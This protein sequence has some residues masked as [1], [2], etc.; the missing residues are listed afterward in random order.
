ME[1]SIKKISRSTHPDLDNEKHGIEYLM[2]KITDIINYIALNYTTAE[3]TINNLLSG[4]LKT[5]GLKQYKTVVNNII[6]SIDNYDSLSI[7]SLNR[8]RKSLNFPFHISFL[9]IYNKLNNISNK[10]F[11]IDNLNIVGL[12]IIIDY[13]VAEIME[14]AGNDTISNKKKRITKNNI[15]LAID[16]DDEL[17][18]LFETI[19]EKDD[20]NIDLDKLKL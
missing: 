10:K 8:K 6:Q 13:L 17:K 3:D 1:T 20:S 16:N 7:S 12:S 18:L 11:I 4:G 19:D 15:I 14:L 5:H 2:N 9:I